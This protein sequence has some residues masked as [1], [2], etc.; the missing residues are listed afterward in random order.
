MK[1]E[2]MIA[3]IERHKGEWDFIVIGGGATGVGTAIEAASRGYKVLLM[4]QSDFGKGTSSRSTKLVHGGVRYLQQ[5]NLSLVLEALKERGLLRKNAPHLVHDLPFIVP[6]YDWWEGPFY[7]IGLKLYDMLAGKEGF[8]SSKLLSK[9]ET[10]KHIPTVEPDGLSG[11]VIYYDGQFDDARLIINMAETAYEQGA[12]L[13]NYMKVDSLI[14]SNSVVCGVTATDLEASKTYELRAKA[15]INATGV[16]SDSVRKMDD[17]N[18]TNIV[19]GSQG[20]HIVLDRSFLPGDSAIMVPHT[21]DGRV[22]FAI[23]WHD[24][25]LVGTTDNEVDD[26]LLEPIPKEGE[27]EFLLTHTARY[28]TKDPKRS[29]ILS[30]FSG[31]RP[32]VKS[33]D[34]ENTAAI[35]RDHT[36]LISRSGLVTICGGKWTT[37]RKMAED[38]IDH[39]AHLAQLNEKPSVT[40]RLQIHGCHN[41][42]AEFGDL[43]IYGSD[44]I[45]IKELYRENKSYKDIL[46]PKFKTTHGEVVWAVRNE[47]ART[48]DD[49]LSRRTRNLLLDAK[50]SV[51]AAPAV[52]KIMA[53]ELGK[54]RKWMKNQIEEF[55]RIAN[56]Y[57]VE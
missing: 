7:G 45:A 30:V 43:E 28:L 49:F 9:E 38:V 3:Q 53:K 56:N 46:H 22:L 23:P 35:S 52:S 21:D 27:I 34:A 37:Y 15:V 6:N 1:R 51:E 42:A 13:V 41:H 40:A 57:I 19:V 31:L 47:M 8:G 25:I 12:V 17:V 36:I 26:Y 44:A 29:D 33:G 48:V 18:S 16:F 32:L 39:A 5:G 4:E 14:K 55:N 20:T 24:T 11:G 2:N 50:A 10:I 54:N